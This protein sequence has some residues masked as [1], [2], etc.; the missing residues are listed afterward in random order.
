MNAK[1]DKKED[2]KQDKKEE[3][4]LKIENIV[5]LPKICFKCNKPKAEKGMFVMGVN[6][7]CGRPTSYT[8]ELLK[9]AYEYLNLKMPCNEVTEVFHTFVGLADYLDIDKDTVR[10]WDR[11]PEKEEFSAIL[12][13]IKT[14][15]EKALIFGGVTEL[16]GQTITKLMLTK[17]GYRDAVDNF[18]T[19]IP[20]D[21]EVKAKSDNA[22]DNYLG[23]K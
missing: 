6:C 5:H 11:D 12:R 4:E 23:K 21:P 14:K 20:I 18:N 3:I 2:I 16:Y 17:H 22:L 19:E 15:Q 8:P 7:N 1:E 10:E 13:K 9:K